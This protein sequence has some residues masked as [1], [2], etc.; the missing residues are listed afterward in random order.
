MP[1]ENTI[2]NAI[3]E[4]LDDV[5]K[6][7]AERLEKKRR[8]V[9]EEISSYPPPIP[10]CDAQFNYL[11]EARRGIARELARLEDVRAGSL[12]KDDFTASISRLVEESA[13][14]DDDARRELR[15]Q[16]KRPQ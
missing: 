10:A 14:L 8:Q 16:L 11:L 2:A 3:P 15:S 1:T 7:L 9:A 12:S 6:N 4:V 13:Y 5:R